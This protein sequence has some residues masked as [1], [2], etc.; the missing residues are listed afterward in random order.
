MRHMLGGTW[1]SRIVVSALL[2]DALVASLTRGCV[3]SFFGQVLGDLGQRWED[4]QACEAKRPSTQSAEETLT[5]LG[6]QEL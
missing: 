6:W 2:V 5:S 3:T 1:V 4:H